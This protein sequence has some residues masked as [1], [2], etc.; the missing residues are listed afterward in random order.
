MALSLT[1]HICKP[2]T[3]PNSFPSL[4]A[5]PCNRPHGRGKVRI[6]MAP[7]EGQAHGSL[8]A[9]PSQSVWICISGLCPGPSLPPLYF[10]R[11]LIPSH[12][13]SY[14][15]CRQVLNSS[16]P[17]LKCVDSAAFWLLPSTVSKVAQ[18]VSKSALSAFLA[19]PNP[20]P[21]PGCLLW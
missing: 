13:C 3:F 10:Q 15:L 6:S 19:W 2:P 17:N 14:S 11:H 12:G 18:T 4:S 1:A 16:F 20:A 21:P 7:P 8:P 5:S 9:V